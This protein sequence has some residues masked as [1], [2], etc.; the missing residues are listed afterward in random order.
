[1]PFTSDMSGDVLENFD[2]D[3]FLQ[4]TASEDFSF[5]PSGLNAYGAPDGVEA[6]AG[7]TWSPTSGKE[8]SVVMSSTITLDN[9]L[10]HDTLI[11]M[12]WR[13]WLLWALK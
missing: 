2:F 7:D 12:M 5:D 1:M 9:L 10:S 13:P 11:S 8:H 3:S 4:G 6:G